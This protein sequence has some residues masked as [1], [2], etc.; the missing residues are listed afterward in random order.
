MQILWSTLVVQSLAPQKCKFFA[1][2]IIQNRVWTAD[3][4]Q[5]RG[6][7]NCNLCPLCKQVQETV[8]HLL[9]QC[10]FTMRVWTEIKNWFGLRDVDPTD[11]RLAP[12]VEVWWDERNARNFR[13]IAATTTV[14]ITKI[15]D[16]ASLWARAGVKYLS[17]AMPG[18]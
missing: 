15:K 1:W 10:R 17:N 5:R 14:I 2:L 13:N 6:W 9:F 8:P 4:L 18:E 3:R 16:E 7:P 11:W 12:S